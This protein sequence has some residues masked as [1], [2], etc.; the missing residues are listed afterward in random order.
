MKLQRAT[1]L[2]AVACVWTAVACAPLSIGQGT[3]DLPPALKQLADLQDSLAELIAQVEPSVVAISRAPSN[4][5]ASRRDPFLDFDSRFGGL[6]GTPRD[7]FDPVGTGVVIGADGVILTQYLNVRRGDQ[8]LVTLSDGR[9]LPAT[10]K[11]ADPRSG[12]AVLQV[13]ASGLPA[14]E[15]GDADALAKGHFVMTLGNPQSIIASGEPT[16]SWGMVSNIAQQAT[17]TTN[18][19]NTLD[20]GGR[21]YAT[22]LHHLGTLLQLDARLNWSNGG[23]VVVDMSGK[24]VG[25]TT[26][27]GTLP[28]HE[29]PAGYAIPMTRIFRRIVDDLKAGREVE[30]GL[31][32]LTL[33]PPQLLPAGAAGAVVD[34]VVPGSAA[35]KA[36]IRPED[37]L[38]EVD[39]ETIQTVSDLQLNVSSLPPNKPVTVRLIRDGRDLKLPVTLSKYYVRGDKLFTSGVRSWRG[40]KVDYSTAFPTS[41]IEQAAMQSRVDPDGCVVVVEVE[42]GSVA[43]QAGIKRGMFVSHVGEQRVTTPDEFYA[44]VEGAGETVNLRF[45]GP[46]AGS[47][48]AMEEGPGVQIPP[49]E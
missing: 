29:S 7:P 5:A 49:T 40:L 14:L 3:A 8:H 42:P 43:D 47:G 22:T 24:L 20:E 48:A 21:S 46:A 28:G 19:N 26:V 33:Q 12:L 9:K 27:A 31:L 17:P 11:A 13:S 39:G 32:G 18:L 6:L 25:I 45:A 37:R 15:F 41:E 30:Y 36:G 2:P 10:I 38:I 35:A 16:A 34:R 23:G 4:D 44:A 1:W